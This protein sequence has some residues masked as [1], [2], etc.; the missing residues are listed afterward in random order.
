MVRSMGQMHA[1][2]VFGGGLCVW[3]GQASDGG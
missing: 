3:E 2:V 1:T